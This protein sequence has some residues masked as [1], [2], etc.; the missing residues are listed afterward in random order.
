MTIQKVCSRY[1]P[2]VTPSSRNRRCIASK[3]RGGYA[4]N[5]EGIIRQTGNP[6]SELSD[7]D[8]PSFHAV[9]CYHHESVVVF[10]A[11]SVGM[12]NATLTGEVQLHDE[13]R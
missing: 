8:G 12:A 9:F 2:A 4:L 3:N 10:V 11:L 6:K 1:T 13:G 7:S 5:G